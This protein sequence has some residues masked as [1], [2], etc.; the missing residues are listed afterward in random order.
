M[1]GPSERLPVAVVRLLCR[2][3]L[4]V[5][6]QTVGDKKGDAVCLSNQESDR[7]GVVLLALVVLPRMLT[8]LRQMTVTPGTPVNLT[9]R[10]PSHID[11]DGP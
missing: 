8:I 7:G 6:S 2:Q 3:R 11:H 4:I 5:Q 9:Q 10:Q 1:I